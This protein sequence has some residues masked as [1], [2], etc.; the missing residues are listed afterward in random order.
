MKIKF[1]L[2]LVIQI[3]N[4]SQQ[5]FEIDLS[6]FGKGLYFIKV[7]SEEGVYTKK[8]ILN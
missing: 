5:Q 8:L 3:S 2:I 7:N 1:L 6:A 4:I